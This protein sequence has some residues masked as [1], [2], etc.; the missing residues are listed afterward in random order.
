VERFSRSFPNILIFPSLLLLKER[1]L[2]VLGSV[3]GAVYIAWSGQEHGLFLGLGV[4]AGSIRTHTVSMVI[5][6]LDMKLLGVSTEGL[7]SAN[8]AFLMGKAV[9]GL[10]ARLVL[11]DTRLNMAGID[12]SD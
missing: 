11:Y 5:S 3:G 12:F 10:G 8:L 9:M 1:F 6:L 4:L 7:L 2:W